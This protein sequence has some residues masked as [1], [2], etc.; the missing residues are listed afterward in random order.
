M[1]I[2]T[3][4]SLA[5]TLPQSILRDVAH[6]KTDGIVGRV[7]GRH[8]LP[9][10]HFTGIASVLIRGSTDATL[11]LHTVTQPEITDADEDDSGNRRLGMP[12]LPPLLYCYFV[13]LRG[14]KQLSKDWEESQS[15][16][17]S[18]MVWVSIFYICFHI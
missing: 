16:L 4:L 11:H 14:E 9:R 12:H 2:G 6:E 1:H 8:F 5:A 15:Q 10:C 3:C 18:D 13:L 7:P 17:V